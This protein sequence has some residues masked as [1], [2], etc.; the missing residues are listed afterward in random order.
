MTDNMITGPTLN[1]CY[2]LDIAICY[3]IAKYPAV[4]ATWC[5]RDSLTRQTTRYDAAAVCT[6]VLPTMTS[7]VQRSVGTKQVFTLF[8]NE[9]ETAVT[10]EVRRGGLRATFTKA[11]QKNTASACTHSVIAQTSPPVPQTRLHSSWYVVTGTFSELL[12]LYR[13]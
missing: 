6:A 11:L 5:V 3:A 8:L 4:K 2:T 10:Y 12:L 7:C 13:Y 9:N 1:Y